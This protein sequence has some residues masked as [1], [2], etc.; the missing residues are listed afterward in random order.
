M[1][2]DMFYEN[3]ML[4]NE[5][6]NLRTRVK[7]MQDTIDALTTKNTNLLSE[8]ASGKWIGTD[9]DDNQVADM[10]HSYLKEIEDLRAKLMESNYTCETLC[11]QMSKV[12]A[13]CA[14]QANIIDISLGQGP[15]ILEEAKKD[16]ER[17]KMLL[18]KNKRH[19]ELDLDISD[20]S[21]GERDSECEDKDGNSNLNDQLMVLTTDIDMKQKLIDELELSQRRIQTMKQHYEDKLMQLQARIRNTQEERDQVLQSYSGRPSKDD[22]VKK[23]KDEYTRKLTDMQKELNRLQSAQ[24]EHTR[25][26]RTQNNKEN[27]LQSFK[28]ELAEMKHTK[29]KLM[30]KMKEESQRHKESEMRKK[31]EIAQLLKESRKNEN[32]IKNMEAKRRLKDKVLKRKQEEVS[33]LRKNQMGRFNPKIAGK[34]TE[35]IYSKKIAN[36]KWL[37]LEKCIHNIA[38]SKRGIVEQEVRMEHFLEKRENL[39]K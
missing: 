29:V 32:T 9:S 3:T 16:L 28:N 38:M 31:R 21:D 10:V 19:S 18:Q 23:V 8:K 7:A 26:L 24:K 35:K 17:E 22:K 20:N 2:N 34:T 30:K 11:K 1:V 37:K 14:S 39:G 4:Q 13:R 36:Q 25:L 5:L 15:I 33:L 12:P 27:Q 6:N